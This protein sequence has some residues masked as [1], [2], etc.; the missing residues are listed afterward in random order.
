MPLG[1]SP[2][3]LNAVSN[4]THSAIASQDS[5]RVTTTF[6]AHCTVH[7]TVED[8][9]V[10]FAN[11]DAKSV[12]YRIVRVISHAGAQCTAYRIMELRLGPECT[13]SSVSSCEGIVNCECEYKKLSC[14]IKQ[15]NF[16]NWSDTFLYDQ[17]FRSQRWALF[18]FVVPVKFSLFVHVP[19]RLSLGNEMVSLITG[20]SYCTPGK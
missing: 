5:S 3:S 16:T 2:I 8:F 12:R 7:S 1:R 9:N 15:W 10:N 4:I 19:H 6:N 11:H 14:F 13:Q 20:L 17:S 18:S